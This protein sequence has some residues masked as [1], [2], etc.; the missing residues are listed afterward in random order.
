MKGLI[1]RAFSDFVEA[2][3]GDVLA[4]QM[5]SQPGLVTNGAYTTVGHYDHSEFLTLLTF[6][7]SRIQEPPAELTKQFGIFLFGYLAGMHEEL[8]RTYQ[9]CFQLLCALDSVVHREVKKLY[10]SNELPRFTVE[11]C[12]EN[13]LLILT[14]T[15]SRPFADLAEGLISG[16]LVHFGIQQSHSLER[17]NITSDGTRSRFIL[18]KHLHESD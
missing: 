2:E 5:L 8:L 3:Y 18:R 11:T 13:D 10:Q 17:E 14:Y 4:D 15:S 12:I 7:S 1:F 6:V 16:S 9:T